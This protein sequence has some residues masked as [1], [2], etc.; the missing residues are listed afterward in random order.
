MCGLSHRPWASRSGYSPTIRAV[1]YLARC[2]D[3]GM[4]DDG[5]KG[6]RGVEDYAG[7]NTVIIENVL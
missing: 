4:S 1:R 2:H 7:G 6:G 5:Q 3:D